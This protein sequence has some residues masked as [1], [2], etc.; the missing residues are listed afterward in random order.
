MQTSAP[1]ATGRPPGSLP[2]HFRQDPAQGR[3]EQP[4]DRLP[5]TKQ[6]KKGFH[7]EALFWVAS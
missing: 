7:A 4:P 3:H 2:E 5:Y 1:S 6:T